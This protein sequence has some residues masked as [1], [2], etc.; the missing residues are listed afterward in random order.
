MLIFLFS[1]ENKKSY[2]LEARSSLI[3]VLGGSP[4]IGGCLKIRASITILSA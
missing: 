2:K 1:I 3:A 4:K